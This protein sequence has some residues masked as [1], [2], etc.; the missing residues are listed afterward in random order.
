MVGLIWAN[1]LY[2]AQNETSNGFTPRWLGTRLFLTQ[3]LSPYSEQVNEAIQGSLAT[4]ANQAP[5][6]YL[7]PFYSFIFYL[8][9]GMT[10]NQAAARLV[11]MTLLELTLLSFLGLSIWLS[12]WRAPVWGLILV[13]V[14]GLLWYYS[15]RSVLDNDLALVSA[16]LIGLALFTLRAEQD[17]LSGFLLAL[18]TIKPTM[19]LLPA[20]FILLWAGSA[21]RWQVVW[22][23]FGSLV[24]MVAATSLLVPDWLPANIRQV[25][26]YGGLNLNNTP[27]R[28]IG[29]WLPG[30]GRQMGWALTIFTIALLAWEWRLSLGKDF[31][32]FYWT[33]CLTLAAAPL[34][35][36][37]V[38]LNNYVLLLPS[39]VLIFGTWHERWGL[40]GRIMIVFSSL[41]L[42]LGVWWLVFS[43]LQREMA[44][45]LNPW[46]YLV[47]PLLMIIGAYWVRWWALN[48]ARLPLEELAENL[49]STR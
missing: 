46:L 38:S 19:V 1:H 45:D 41:I 47:T 21:K 13:F 18:A 44:P 37:P 17:A 14:V 34:I 12:R 4:G 25:V 24:L 3:G 28:L 6:Y 23:F 30:I 7:Y 40:V 35:G 48:P 31:R 15:V 42:T 2:I 29:Y 22:G 33:A 11:W 20:V 5:G 32:W 36:L 16:M 39:L 8:P 43:G 10:D 49:G 9:F 26:E 27:G